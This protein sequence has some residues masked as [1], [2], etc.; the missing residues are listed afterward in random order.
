MSGDLTDN[1]ARFLSPLKS[2]C[3]RSKAPLYS[4]PRSSQIAAISVRSRPQGGNGNCIGADL[5][6]G[7]LPY[8]RFFDV[9]SGS[10]AEMD[11]PVGRRGLRGAFSFIST[12][13][14]REYLNSG[15]VQY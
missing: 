3:V 7:Y 12:Q 15:V 11:A 14:W 13:P 1:R 2:A 5:Q 8:S 10:L 4:Q 6:P 9:Y